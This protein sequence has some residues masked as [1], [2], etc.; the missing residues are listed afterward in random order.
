MGTTLA[1]T[2]LP[3]A[4][5]PDGQ[6]SRLRCLQ[7]RVP[8]H[9][10]C[11]ASEA[12]SMWKVH[13]SQGR[14][15]EHSLPI[16]QETKS[17]EV[18]AY[19]GSFRSKS[20]GDPAAA[21]CFRFSVRDSRHYLPHPRSISAQVEDSSEQPL[22]MVSPFLFAVLQSWSSG[23]RNNLTCLKLWQKTGVSLW[24]AEH[25]SPPNRGPRRE[26]VLTQRRWRVAHSMPSGGEKQEECSLLSLDVSP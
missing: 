17:W 13:G 21:A 11:W 1:Q 3:S 9:A 22:F 14:S 16:D 10:L 25:L 7:R 8:A 26:D 20:V 24:G 4:Q 2:S 5:A 15:S 23:Q 19:S 18:L 6:L 12:R